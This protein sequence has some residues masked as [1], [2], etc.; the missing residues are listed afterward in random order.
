MNEKDYEKLREIYLKVRAKMKNEITIPDLFK[1]EDFW[2]W[3]LDSDKKKGMANLA[4]ARFREWA[5]GLE[6]RYSYGGQSRWYEHE[7]EVTGS[8][9]PVV[10]LLAFPQAIKKECVHEPRLSF[11]SLIIA[12]EI[13]HKCFTHCLKC[14]QRLIAKWEAAE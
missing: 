4:N 9:L 10:A 11:D 7:H 5:E 6:K 13:K 1:A 8:P 14:G 3:G 2:G 12:A